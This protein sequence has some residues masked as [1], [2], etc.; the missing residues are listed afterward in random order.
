MLLSDLYNCLREWVGKLQSCFNCPPRKLRLGLQHGKQDVDVEVEATPLFFSSDDC[1]RSIRFIRC[2]DTL[3]P[4]C[5]RLILNHSYID[6][7][8]N[9][10]LSLASGFQE[11]D[12]LS[13]IKSIISYTLQCVGGQAGDDRDEYDGCRRSRDLKVSRRSP[14]LRSA[15]LLTWPLRY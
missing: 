9:N 6:N 14:F 13:E 10:T 7:L 3:C 2:L 4:G 12:Q 15:Q 11:R 1:K 8:S 5:V